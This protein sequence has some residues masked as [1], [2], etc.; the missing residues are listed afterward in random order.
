MFASQWKP[1]DAVQVKYFSTHETSWQE[2]GNNVHVLIDLATRPAISALL[3]SPPLLMLL[4][5]NKLPIFLSGV[6]AANSNVHV[7]VLPGTLCPVVR[8]FVVL[9]VELTDADTD[10]GG[11]SGTMCYWARGAFRY[12]AMGSPFFFFFFAFFLYFFLIP[13]SPPLKKKKKNTHDGPS[14]RELTSF[15]CPT[16]ARAESKQ[17]HPTIS[18]HLTISSTVSLGVDL[19]SEP[20]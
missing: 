13:S 3:P 10:T 5:R 19:H 14:F 4:F 16:L 6:V 17:E 12:P 7:S 8:L 18:P 2:E 20:T 11:T 1:S 9:V 15:F